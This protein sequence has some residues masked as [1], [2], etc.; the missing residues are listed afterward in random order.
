MQQLA[1]DVFHLLRLAW[2]VGI[3]RAMV[4]IYRQSTFAAWCVS[5]VARVVVVVVC[6]VVGVFELV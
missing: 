4:G 1:C 3:Q 2:L 6:C 5:C